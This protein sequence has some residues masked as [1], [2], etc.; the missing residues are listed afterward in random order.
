M[1]KKI[2]LLFAFALA[3]PAASY[4]LVGGPWDNGDYSQILDETGIYQATLRF[5]NGQGF[6][7]FGSNVS[8]STFRDLTLAT[9]GVGSGINLNAS[10]GSYL[11]RSLIY[12]KG[13]TYL[14][15]CYGTSDMVNNLIEGITNGNSDVTTVNASGAATTTTAATAVSTTNVLVANGTRSFTC[16]TAWSAKI[17]TK[18]PVLKFNGKGQL[19]VL[20]PDGIAQVTPA[21]NALLATLGGLTVPQL[22]AA[23]P[24]GSTG[25]PN[26]NAIINTINQINTGQVT[27]PNNFAPTIGSLADAIP[28]TT[29][30][31]TEKNSDQVPLT[32]FGIRKFFLSTR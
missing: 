2:Q 8:V 14:G 32:V 28:K 16:N 4:G 19:T 21:V 23:P 26:V 9:S 30:E 5:S 27:S 10:N 20:N 29:A 18:K 13:V 31:L 6:C 1:L 25:N 11:N 22:T 24:A 7:Q 12:Y 17:T 3:L 15:S